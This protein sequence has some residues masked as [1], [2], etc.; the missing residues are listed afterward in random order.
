MRAGGGTGDKGPCMDGRQCAARPSGLRRRADCWMAVRAGRGARVEGPGSGEV[1]R[2]TA[3]GGSVDRGGAA[4]DGTVA[5]VLTL[6]AVAV[7]V[8]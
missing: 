4:A 7:A 1:R 2:S 5:T 6:S 8:Q 3:L